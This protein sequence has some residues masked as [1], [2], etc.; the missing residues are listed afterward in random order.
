MVIHIDS[1]VGA[2]SLIPGVYKLHQDNRT[3]TR[4]LMTGY[5]ADKHR[6][7]ALMSGKSMSDRVSECCSIEISPLG[8]LARSKTGE[9]NRMM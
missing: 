5:S 8:D 4:L 7:W 3:S 6:H 2:V 1:F 9:W